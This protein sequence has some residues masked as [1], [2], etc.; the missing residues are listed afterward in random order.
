MPARDHGSGCPHRGSG[1]CEPV[2]D[3]CWACPFRRDQSVEWSI[4]APPSHPSAAAPSPPVDPDRGDGQPDPELQRRQEGART[5][6]VESGAEREKLRNLTIK[7]LIS[8]A[9]AGAGYA[10]AYPVWASLGGP[11]SWYASSTLGPVLVALTVLLTK[12]DPE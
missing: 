12:R 5:E 6:K 7:I 2:G 3:W 8:L 4:E 10:M 1:D 9:I 11:V